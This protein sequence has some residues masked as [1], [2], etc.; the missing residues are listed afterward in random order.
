MYKKI[1]ISTSVQLM[2]YLLYRKYQQ[3][4]FRVLAHGYYLTCYIY[5]TYKMGSER[6]HTGT[7][8]RLLHSYSL[9]RVWGRWYVSPKR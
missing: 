6:L 9:V 2:S 5:Y 8:V 1:F 3:S 7:S 4:E